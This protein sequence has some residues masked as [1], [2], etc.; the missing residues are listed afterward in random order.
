VSSPGTWVAGP[1]MVFG[2][3]LLGAV[4]APAAMMANGKNSLRARSYHRF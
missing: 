4:D 3:N 1:T 2:T